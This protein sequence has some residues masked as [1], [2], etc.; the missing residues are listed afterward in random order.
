[1]RQGYEESPINPLPA[2]VWALAL[3]VIA[4]EIVF[5][6][7][8]TGMIGGAGGIGLRGRAAEMAA[9]SPE[10][11]LRF[12]QRGMVPWDQLYRVLSYPF[13]HFGFTHAA[14]V[15]VFILALGKVLADSFRPAAV[16]GLFFGSAVIAAV[17]YTAIAAVGAVYVPALRFNPLLG[18]YP[19]VYGFVGAFTFLL[20]TRLGQ[21]GGN[22]MRAFSLIGMLLA[23]QLVF[24]LIFGGGGTAWIGEIAGFAAGFGLSFLLIPGGPAQVRRALRQR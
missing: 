21:T 18:G 10:M 4:S 3:P 12:W 5:G 13:I 8:Q 16:L 2:V 9:Y 24:G 22:R 20:W 19:A 7:G 6:L 23:F 1:M 15:T 14:F 17:V 11:M